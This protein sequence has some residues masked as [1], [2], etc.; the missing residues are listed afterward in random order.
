M[1]TSVGKPTGEVAELGGQNPF[2]DGTKVYITLPGGKREGFAFKPT[3]DPLSQYLRGAGSVDSD[4]NI[5]HPSFVG[6][7]GV[8]D[9]LTVQN[10]RII[11]G[12]GTNQYYGLAGSAYNPADVYFGGVYTLT[13]KEGIVYQIDAA[14]GDLLTVTDTNGNTLTYTDADITSSTGQ[15]ITFGRDAQGRIATVTDPAGKQI[16]YDYNAQGDL[17]SVT[18]R[19]GNT[20]RMEYD[21]ERKHYLDKIIDPLGRTGVK[22]EYG[23][24][25][26]L[27][28]MVDAA[29]A[30]VQLAYDPSH[31]TETINDALGNPTTYEYDERGN[32]VTEID[33]LGGII[34]RDYDQDNNLLKKVDPDG[35]STTY[36]YD[37][38]G[39]P[40]TITDQ[41]GN[42]TRITY[43]QYG[44]TLNIILPTG[45]IVSSTYDKHGNLSSRTNTDG[46]TTTFTTMALVN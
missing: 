29:G 32:V 35:V 33:A 9:T 7:A 13:T 14:T 45:L 34:T 15:K 31:S 16:R 37:D 39:N 8:T 17:I 38:K 20:T 42:V 27:K 46:Q 3:I 28:K 12:A 4:P 24:D 36:T 18:D 11:H 2:K 1:R 23:D 19:E 21:Q 30:S 25:G 22:N 43:N 10:T 26:R 44:E 40:L 41:N 5:Y 6:D